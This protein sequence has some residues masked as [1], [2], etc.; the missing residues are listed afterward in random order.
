M[1]QYGGYEREPRLLVLEAGHG[2]ALSKADALPRHPPSLGARCAA[3][4]NKELQAASQAQIAQLL[5]LKKE[6]E[7]AEER[8]AALLP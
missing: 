7:E 2:L 8:C 6:L 1:K 4:G 5:K 3:Q